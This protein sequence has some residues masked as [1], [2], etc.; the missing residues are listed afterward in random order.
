MTSSS[1]SSTLAVER[2]TTLSLLDVTD[3]AVSSMAL[4]AIRADAERGMVIM[5]RVCTCLRLLPFPRD[6]SRGAVAVRASWSSSPTLLVAANGA[7]SLLFAD[8][9][10]QHRR[11]ELIEVVGDGY[12]C[13]G[14]I[15]QRLVEKRTADNRGVGGDGAMQGS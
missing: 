7:T 5:T 14:V 9:G 10:W 4:F 8:D 3:M 6:G 2:R 13:R 11:G 15:P 1:W 12:G